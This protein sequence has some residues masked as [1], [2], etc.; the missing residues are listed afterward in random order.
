M[1]KNAINKHSIMSEQELAEFKKNLT[2]HIDSVMKNNKAEIEDSMHD[3]KT[4]NTRIN[5]YIIQKE[6]T[7]EMLYASTKEQEF[8]QT[9][10]GQHQEIQDNAE[11]IILF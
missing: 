10:I 4:L 2:N 1:S 5:E 3:Y 7:G 11:S 8:F 6:H 9:V